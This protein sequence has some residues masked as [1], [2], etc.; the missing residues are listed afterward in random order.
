LLNAKSTQ[1]LPKDVDSAVDWISGLIGVAID[2]RVTA[3]EQQARVNP[4]LASHFPGCGDS[5]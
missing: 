4:L 5:P 2:K 1:A 3:F